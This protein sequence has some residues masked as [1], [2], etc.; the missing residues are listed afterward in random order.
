MHLSG[1]ATAFYSCLDTY[2][3]SIP[4]SLSSLFSGCSY[5]SSTSW[6]GNHQL[7]SVFIAAAADLRRVLSSGL[8]FLFL[9]CLDTYTTGFHPWSELRL[10]VCAGCCSLACSSCFF[11]ALK[12]TPH[13]RLGQRDQVNMSFSSIMLHSVV[14]SLPN[15]R[16]KKS[17]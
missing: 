16:P 6:A 7:H 10:L 13:M 8:L 17:G 9:F 3:M 15:L 2:A 5:R 11:F 4:T 1:A 12:H 14:F